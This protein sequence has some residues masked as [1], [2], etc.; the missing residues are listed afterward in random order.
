MSK[1]IKI[2]PNDNLI[3]AINDLEKGEKIIL[4]N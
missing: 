1:A 4:E 2:H 3:V